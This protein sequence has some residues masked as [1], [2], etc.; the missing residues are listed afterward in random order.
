MEQ[1]GLKTDR[2]DINRQITKDNKQLQKLKELQKT[3]ELAIKQEQKNTLQTEQKQYLTN[4]ENNKQKSPL[5]TQTTEKQL[6]KDIIINSIKKLKQQDNQIIQQI[7]QLQ[8]LENN[9]TNK[10]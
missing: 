6:E 10:H 3:E 8:Q 9:I 4:K 2:G 5:P 7:S 1:K